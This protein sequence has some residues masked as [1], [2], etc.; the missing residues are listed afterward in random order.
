M[1]PPT[2]SGPPPHLRWVGSYCLSKVSEGQPIAV[3]GSARGS[4]RGWGW[5]GQGG[6][7]AVEPA[8]VVER[9]G[10][11]VG[12]D[13]CGGV[14]GG[15]GEHFRDRPGDGERGGAGRI[16]GIGGGWGER[17]GGIAIF[18]E[19]DW[20]GRRGGAG[21]GVGGGTGSGFGAGGRRAALLHGR[22]EAFGHVAAQQEHQQLFGEARAVIDKMAV[23]ID[24]CLVIA[25]HRALH[26]DV[27]QPFGG[28]RDRRAPG[29][30]EPLR[31]GGAAQAIGARL[32]H[33]DRLDRRLDRSQVGERLDEQPLLVGRPAIRT[34]LAQ[35]GQP[36]EIG[37]IMAVRVDA[38]VERRGEV[39][40]IGGRGIRRRRVRQHR[41]QRGVG[42]DGKNEGR[43][44][45]RRG[46]R[47][48][49]G[50]HGGHENIRGPC[51]TGVCW[52]ANLRVFQGASNAQMT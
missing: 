32:R 11:A 1:T 7:G 45:R 28:G 15:D 44:V 21:G 34:R 31:A 25:D 4:G 22:A 14:G 16:G 51:K 40:V 19:R 37:G 46:V 36:V 47:G 3:E 49:G 8:G 33:A 10:E 18:A 9:V 6:E 24:D 43:G 39:R 38:G 20:I 23:L 2:P 41:R 42:G 50:A 13:Q 26:G 29:A 48:R 5:W 17:G 27:D 52:G 30:V 35:H 12:R